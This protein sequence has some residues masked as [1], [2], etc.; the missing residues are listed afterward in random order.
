VTAAGRIAEFVREIGQHSL[1]HPRINRRGGVIVH[2][3]GQSNGVATSFEGA[4]SLG[5]PNGAHSGFDPATQILPKPFRR[6][7]TGGNPGQRFCNFRLDNRRLPAKNTANSGEKVF[8]GSSGPATE[9][10]SMTPSSSPPTPNMSVDINACK[11]PRVKIVAREED[12]EFVECIE[13]G[14]VFES[15]EF[16]DMN[17]EETKLKET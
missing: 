9:P 8:R 11:H 4:L 17:I 5:L 15:S 16:K 2:I 7:R 13:C 14:E 1:E 12:S 6:G 3:N 10:E